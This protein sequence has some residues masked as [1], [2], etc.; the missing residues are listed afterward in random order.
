MIRKFRLNRIARQKIVMDVKSTAVPTFEL[1]WP[2]Y[3]SKQSNLEF[4]LLSTTTYPQEN[5]MRIELHEYD[6]TEVVTL[7]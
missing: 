2:F 4:S 3:D 5:R 7:I 6:D 1:F